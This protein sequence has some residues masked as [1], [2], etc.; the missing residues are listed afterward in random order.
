MSGIRHSNRKKQKAAALRRAGHLT[1]W[2][3]KSLGVSKGSVSLWLSK[4]ELTPAELDSVE[5]SKKRQYLKV[6]MYHRKR[7][8]ER[9]KLA[10]A[11]ADSMLVKFQND[12]LFNMGIGLYWGEGSK[13]TPELQISNSDPALVKVWLQWLKKFAPNHAYRSSLN[14]HD[15]ADK[16]K[17]VEHWRKV[18]IDG[19]LKVYV[20]V[21]K[22]SKRKLEIGRLPNGTISI[23]MGKGSREWYTMMMHWIQMLSSH[24]SE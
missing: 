5:D 23:S 21:S 14:I 3:A 4:L 10:I 8:E 7:A 16:E 22:A 1:P 13:R 15:N 11:E 18:G 2:I 12:P 9:T 6:G 19:G 17:A 24:F 20:S